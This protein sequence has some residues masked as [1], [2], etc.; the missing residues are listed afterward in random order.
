[1]KLRKTLPIDYRNN[2]PFGK[3]WKTGDLAHLI[4]SFSILYL[5]CYNTTYC[6]ED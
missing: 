2:I 6:L 5:L 3:N 4:T 1:M